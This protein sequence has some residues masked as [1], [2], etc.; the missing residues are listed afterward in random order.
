[1][2]YYVSIEKSIEVFELYKPLWV[3]YGINGI[4]A[5]TM[6]EGIENLVGMYKTAYSP[7]RPLSKHDKI[8]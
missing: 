7:N 5:D 8:C 3:S 4:R 2:R 1:M 6:A